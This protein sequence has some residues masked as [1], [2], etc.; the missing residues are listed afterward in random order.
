MNDFSEQIGKREVKKIVIGEKVKEYY[1]S[2]RVE[3]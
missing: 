2:M 1:Y 3:S